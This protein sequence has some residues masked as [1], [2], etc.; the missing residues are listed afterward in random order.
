VTARNPSIEPSATKIASIGVTRES[1]SRIARELARKACTS[2]PD[3]G[4]R[5]R[6]VPSF[7]MIA[8][9]NL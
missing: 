1:E 8:V 3:T 5:Y 2:A 6:T 9:V 4:Q 7:H